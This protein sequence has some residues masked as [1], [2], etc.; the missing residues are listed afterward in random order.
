MNL[1]IDCRGELKVAFNSCGL[2]IEKK[3][4]RL[5]QSWVKSLLDLLIFLKLQSC[6]FWVLIS[7]WFD[8]KKQGAGV[9][10]KMC[11]NEI[12]KSLEIKGIRRSE[13]KTCHPRF[14]IRERDLD[15]INFQTR[16]HTQREGERERKKVS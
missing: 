11:V 6:S 9:R 7:I 5:H 8:P 3:R 13:G 4:V 10:W 1:F 16:T 2:S 15:S 12:I 14:A